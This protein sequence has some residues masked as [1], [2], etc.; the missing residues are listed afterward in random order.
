ML[1]VRM[2]MYR[3]MDM[4]SGLRK[5]LSIHCFKY[6][7]IGAVHTVTKWNESILIVCWDD[8][9]IK[10]TRQTPKWIAWSLVYECLYVKQSNMLQSPSCFLT[11]AFRLH[12]TTW[13]YCLNILLCKIAERNCSLQVSLFVVWRGNFGFGDRE[14]CI[15][16]GCLQIIKTTLKNLDRFGKV[17]KISILTLCASQHA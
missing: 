4:F 8:L 13:G 5:L 11:L 16:P 6:A 7:H 14:E 17:S 1:W 12:K 3:S 10:G 2:Y 15:P 9:P